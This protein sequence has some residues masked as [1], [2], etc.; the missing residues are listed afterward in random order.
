MEA[1]KIILLYQ[2]LITEE[3]QT[4]PFGLLALERM[5]RQDPVEVV[6]KDEKFDTDIF[7]F[8][9]ANSE[10]I[11]II[12]ISVMLSYQVVGAKKFAKKVKQ[13]YNIPILFGG[14]FVTMF[15]N[16]VINENYVDFIIYGQGEVPFKK[17]VGE[18]ISERN[19]LTSVDGLGYKEDGKINI[20]KPRAWEN[21]FNFP[22]YNYDL[23]DV[24]RYIEFG[25]NYLK[26]IGSTG[27]NCKC[28]FCLIGH[29]YGIRHAINTPENILKDIQYFLSKIPELT[30]IE[31]TD[32]NFLLQKK[33]VIAFCQ[34]L[35][36]HNI[37]IKWLANTN[38]KNF[39]DNYTDSD[40][41]IL[42]EAGC[43]RI[44]FGAE[45][46]DPVVL[47]NLNKNHTIEDIIIVYK[48]LLRHKIDVTYLFMFGFPPNPDTDIRKTFKLIMRLYSISPTIDITG[49]IYINLINNFYFQEALKLG[50]KPPTTYQDYEN[51]ILNG[52]KFNYI[53]QK[54]RNI[55]KYF[56]IYYISAIKKEIP[57][58]LD[59][60]LHKTWRII[61]FIW[62]P[63]VKLR[64]MFN[65]FNFT[66]DAAL[67]SL[68]IDFIYKIK[69][70]KKNKLNNIIDEFMR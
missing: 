62:Y 37:K 9:Q 40:I 21:T 25:G 28:N 23:I 13:L 32:A 51:I 57:L 60:K 12:G 35:I 20:N 3:S 50:Y 61:S 43:F 18:I 53:K 17:L 45:S 1:G 7:D 26:Y 44:N 59:K 47:K 10:H 33:P 46:G 63:V 15:P 69:H 11:I 49:R 14:V 27:C 38:I 41:K 16:M 5:V 24:I 4:M 68:L 64:F 42:K 67:I 29:S 2:P 70:I 8:L 6:I 52:V 58:S 22:S 30:H 48:K 66:Y 54:H 39:L 56:G 31:F 34:L 36:S 65:I 55:I 19:N